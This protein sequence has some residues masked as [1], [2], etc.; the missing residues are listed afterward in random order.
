MTAGSDPTGVV[1]PSTNG[2]LL[3]VTEL[4]TQRRGLASIIARSFAIR[5]NSYEALD[6]DRRHC[7]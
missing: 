6:G 3:Q 1:T 2:P 7:A 4:L 5:L